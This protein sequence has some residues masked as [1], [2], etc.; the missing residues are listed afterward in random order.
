[1]SQWE[2]VYAAGHQLNRY[3]YAEVVSFVKRFGR[4]N[5]LNHLWGLDVGCGSGL[6]AQLMAE[7]GA[8]V[9]AFDGSPSAIEHAQRLH[10]HRGITYSVATLGAFDGGGRRFDLVVDRL[11][12]TYANLNTVAN[13]YQSL[14]NELRPGAR[15]FWQGF[16]PE[17]SGQASGHFDLEE[18]IWTGFSSGVF[19]PADTIYFF[20]EQDLGTVCAGYRF[21]SKRLISDT[22]LLTGYRHSYW[23][24]ELEPQPK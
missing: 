16:D 24:L 5:S 10:P 15:V 12:S 17:N 9:L 20:S 11:S 22:D 1:M 6:H 4:Q 18:A 8:Q 14:R 2:S 13:F 7:E 23:S 21:V 19:A 3:P